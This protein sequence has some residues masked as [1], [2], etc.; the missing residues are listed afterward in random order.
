[1][2]LPASVSPSHKFDW[3]RASMYQR[4]A[5]RIERRLSVP[6][7]TVTKG[8]TFFRPADLIAFRASRPLSHPIVS[9]RGTYRT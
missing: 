6:G 1:M 8:L 2:N 5:A 9:R 4:T 7:M 3:T